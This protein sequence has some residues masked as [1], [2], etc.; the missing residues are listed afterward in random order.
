MPQSRPTVERAPLPNLP[1]AFAFMA[2]ADVDALVASSP[3]NVQYLTG[4]SCWLALFREFMVRPGGSDEMVQRNLAFLPLGQDP[5]LVVEPS[6]VLDAVDCWVTDVRVAG[7]AYFV[8]SGATGAVKIVPEHDPA[9]VCLTAGDWPDDPI[10]ALTDLIREKGLQGSRIGLEL[11]S[12]A[13]RD[14][15]ALRAALPG[16]VFVDC[17]G[18]LRIIRAVKTDT[19][20]ER[21]ARAAQIAERAAAEAAETI[22]AGVTPSVLADRFRL[23]LARD[24]ADYD[25]CALSLDGLGFVTS[26]DRMLGADSWMYFD[27]G[28]IYRGWFSDAGTTLCIGEPRDVALRQH[29]AVLEAVEEGARAVRPGVRGSAVQRQMQLALSD[30]GVTDAFPHGHGL[31][32]EI[33]EYP[34]LVPDAGEAIR[35]GCVDLDA[36]LLLE[37]DMVINLEA[38]IL[39]LGECSAHCE[40]TFVV[41]RDGARPLISQDRAMP[42]AG[43]RAHRRGDDV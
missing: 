15:E 32:I 17:S 41:T 1:R 4:Y 18:L 31:G 9:R 24:G 8:R 36:D 30:V 20:I 42:L 25:H 14:V 5:V 33:R 34:I 16:A 12:M 23:S 19:E 29:A 38:S 13:P 26:G 35:D 40:K 11:T 37:P 7:D 27:Y 22:C 2:G 3:A 10:V 6:F 28:C 39:V 21:L 43:G